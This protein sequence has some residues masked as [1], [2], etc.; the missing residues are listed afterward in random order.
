MSFVKT[1]VAIIGAGPAG[2]L[3][4]QILRQEGV[5]CVVI[6]KH[7]REHVLA[8]VRAGVLEPTTVQVLRQY[9]LAARMERDG[10]DTTACRS[11]GPGA[12]AF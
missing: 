6:E 12:R 8:R 2:L 7:S 9:G 11:P 5:E 4:A 3:L 10:H 1:R